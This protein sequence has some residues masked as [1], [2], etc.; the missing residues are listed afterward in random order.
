MKIEFKQQDDGYDVVVDS[1]T[2]G[3]LYYADGGGFYIN[4]GLSRALGC[5]HSF[6]GFSFD[7]SKLTIRG[8]N[9]NLWKNLMESL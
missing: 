4:N 5:T 1:V 8:L 3:E 2:V 6:M 9:R 7:Q